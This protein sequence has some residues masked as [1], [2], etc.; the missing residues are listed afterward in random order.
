M[1]S[2]HICVCNHVDTRQCSNGSEGACVLL[3]RAVR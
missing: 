2:V 3:Q 1:G